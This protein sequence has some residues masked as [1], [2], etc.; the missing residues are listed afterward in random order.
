M[1][2][3]S[4]ECWA[5]EIMTIVAGHIGV[6]DLAT[7]IIM[8]NISSILYMVGLGIQQTVCT[9]FGYAIDIGNV[10]DAKLYFSMF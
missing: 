1:F 9:L 2:M 8:I 5:L 6:I 10:K 4:L 3:I 7:Q